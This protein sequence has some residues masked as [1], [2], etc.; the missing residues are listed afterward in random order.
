MN[1]ITYTKGK[2][3]FEEQIGIAVHG[4]DTIPSIS[5][6]GNIFQSYSN[7]PYNYHHFTGQGSKSNIFYHHLRISYLVAPSIN[8]RAEFGHVYREKK[9]TIDYQ[10]NHYFYVG[11]KT[12]L[13]NRYTDY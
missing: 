6:G 12:N 5:Y 8:L 7:R 9:N 10:S 2:W 13:W 1:F 4:Q 3:I 11:L